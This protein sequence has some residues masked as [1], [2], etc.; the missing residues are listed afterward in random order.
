MEHIRRNAV[1]EKRKERNP[2]PPLFLAHKNI[3]L[4]KRDENIPRIHKQRLSTI[5]STM[6]IYGSSRIWSVSALKLKEKMWTN[7]PGEVGEIRKITYNIKKNSHKFISLEGVAL[8]QWWFTSLPTPIPPLKAYLA[9]PGDIFGC[10]ARDWSRHV[11]HI[12]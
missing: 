7:I 11:I 12:L 10:H 2:P 3:I 6:N 9:E 5:K 1:L 4:N 8:N